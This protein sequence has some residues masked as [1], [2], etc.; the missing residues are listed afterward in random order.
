MIGENGISLEV[1]SAITTIDKLLSDLDSSPRNEEI[2][3][4][5]QRL[6]T[7]IARYTQMHYALFEWKELHYRLQVT[8]MG[9]QHVDLEI[10]SEPIDVA[11]L[12]TIWATFT[13]N[14]LAS[15]RKFA[16]KVKWVDT[17]I[18]TSSPIQSSQAIDWWKQLD[19]GVAAIETEIS[20]ETIDIE[21][22]G[23]LINNLAEWIYNILM[24]FSRTLNDLIR[25]LANISFEIDRAL[26]IHPRE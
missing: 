15:L 21:L 8:E 23:N 10:H 4:Q 9:L 16:R 11:K 7:A 6:S 2:R 18:H 26:S 17:I 24:S 25:G 19:E 5:L 3:F 14:H 1:S 20:H 22:L 13:S 12:K